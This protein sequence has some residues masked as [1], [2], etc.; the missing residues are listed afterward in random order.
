MRVTASLT[1]LSITLL[2]QVKELRKSSAKDTFRVHLWRTFMLLVLLAT[3]FAVTYTT[4][5]FLKEEETENFKTA[6]E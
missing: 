1:Y 4:Y 3:A 2:Q 6:F 5:R